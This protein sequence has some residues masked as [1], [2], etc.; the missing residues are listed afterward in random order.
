[1]QRLGRKL[2]RCIAQTGLQ[3]R[4]LL[5]SEALTDKSETIPRT[6]GRNCGALEVTSLS[7]HRCSR[8][9]GLDKLEIVRQRERLGTL[10]RT[11]PN[12]PDISCEASEF[13]TGRLAPRELL[14]DQAANEGLKRAGSRVAAD[15]ARLR[16]I[17][18]LARIEFA[19]RPGQ[20]E[21]A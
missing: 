15:F 16:E 17:R 13:P 3:S 19:V 5:P 7:K 10:V 20:A 1:M 21:K 12:G 11:S 2:A 14:Y 4:V 18:D 8:D 6:L 9:A